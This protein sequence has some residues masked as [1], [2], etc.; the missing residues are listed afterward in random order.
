MSHNKIKHAIKNYAKAYRS[1]Q[2]WQDN[3]H[4]IPGG[5]QKTGSI[6]EYYTYLYLSSNYPSANIIYGNH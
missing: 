4:A 5:D 2:Y 6:G 3:Q 1:L